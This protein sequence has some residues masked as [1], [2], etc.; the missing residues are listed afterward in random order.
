ML[1]ELSKDM[2]PLVQGELKKLQQGKG[3]Q[4]GGKPGAPLPAGR[5]GAG[6]SD[7]PGAGGDA[8]KPSTTPKD[9]RKEGKGGS[10]GGQGAAKGTAPASGA[11]G[12][13]PGQ[14]VPVTGAEASSPGLKEFNFS[15]PG[16]NP[17][18]PRSKGDSVNLTIAGEID[19]QPYRAQV[20]ATFDHQEQEKGIF[21]TYLQLS[22]D[23]RIEATDRVLKKDIRI[24]S[25]QK[26]R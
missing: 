7:K 13:H 12:G 19:G 3:T 26:K 22:T 4:G 17:T 5:A 10:G 8:G 15:V 1:K 2:L 23:L 14:L 16:F 6:A 24:V 21:T 20:T 11:K 25:S 9:P 18:L